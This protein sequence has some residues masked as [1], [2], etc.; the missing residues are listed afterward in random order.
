MNESLTLN[1]VH[2]VYFVYVCVA[3]NIQDHILSKPNIRLAASQKRKF[4][5]DFS[6]NR[7]R[8]KDIKSKP[9]KH[10][11]H[12]LAIL[13]TYPYPL[14]VVSMMSLFQ[15]KVQNNSLFSS[16][17]VKFAWK[18]IIR[19]INPHIINACTRIFMHQKP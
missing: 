18:A 8:T 7:Y 2:F 16:I 11:I 1:W 10:A 17:R 3:N 9:K 13:V 15:C 19:N 6:M 5:T 4:W 14:L 12:H